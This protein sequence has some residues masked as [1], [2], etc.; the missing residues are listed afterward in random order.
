MSPAARTVHGLAVALTL[1]SAAQPSGRAAADEPPNRGPLS[2][3][4]WKQ[5]ATAL[6]KW[7]Q[8]RDL[9][10]EAARTK[11]LAAAM[12]ERLLRL[13]VGL[14]GGESE[15]PEAAALDAEWS[16]HFAAL[17]VRCA[18][19]AMARMAEAAAEKNYSRAVGWLNEALRADPD[20]AAARELLGD[21]RN[22]DQW[23]TPFAARQREQGRL[24]S[25][26]FGWI[27]AEHAERY[28]TGQR[29]DRS[30]WITAEEDAR[31]H[32]NIDSP[33]RVFTERYAVATNHSLE[34]GVKLAARLEALNRTWSMLFAAYGARSGGQLHKA[35]SQG[36][37]LGPAGRRHA[38]TYFKDKAGFQQGVAGKLPTNVETSG[39]YLPAARTAYFYHDESDDGATLIHE[40]VHQLFS[41]RVRGVRS[42]GE[43]EGFWVIE[44]I[45]CYF[46]SLRFHDDHVT[47]GGVDA[48]RLQDARF[49]F[50]R[51][52][53]YVPLAEFSQ[54]GTSAWQR[55]GE[56]R[57]IRMMYA[58]AAA[59][60]DFLMHADQGAYRD[61]LV[62]Y[63]ARVYAGR[64][65]RL[66]QVLGIPFERLDERFRDWLR[67]GDE[68]LAAR[69][70]GD[71]ASYF[72]L[73]GSRVTDAGLA[74]LASLKRITWLD[75]HGT[76][77]TDAGMEHVAKL[78]T[79]RRLDLSG[80]KV[81]DAGAALLAPL[82]EL[83]SLDLTDTNVSDQGVARIR[84]ALPN[85]EIK[86]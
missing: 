16:R 5:D 61:A 11:T 55:R 8:E 6:A 3:A 33:W 44:G 30:V 72:T 82:A 17:R 27:A 49:Y 56:G 64:P 52:G 2:S 51:D 34:E 78:T 57:E 43:R 65:A 9:E 32:A 7:C 84:A 46:E 68:D 47:L 39:V 48:Y 60:C 76:G 42:P 24:W 29:F 63:L 31:R 80:T 41:E 26:R 40:A 25:P 1:L 67:I 22:D 12:P 45:A 14:D 81:G 85:L 74:Q 53:F 75:L 50:F 13:E 83:D 86:R 58:Q 19:Q 62:D 69:S 79:L 59:L 66:D 37:L 54:L 23:L 21:V 70:L 4:A 20:C 28:E 36:P 15:A 38:V 73:G 71:A 35:F 18:E 10:T 77:V